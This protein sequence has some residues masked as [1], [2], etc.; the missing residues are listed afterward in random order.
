[1]KYV[2]LLILLFL[3]LVFDMRSYKVPN[4]LVLIGY[5]TGTIS[6]CMQHGAAGILISLISIAI[7]WL[8]FSPFFIIRGLGGGDCKLLA[9][10]PLFLRYE[11][12]LECYFLIFA[13]A[14][15]V[16]ILNYFISRKRR[17]RFSIAAF[18]GVVIL[19]IKELV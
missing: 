5:M 10:V 17:F 7:V 19:Y 18:L 13:C 2:I 9:W 11:L 1:M 14:G 4:V 3:A 8:I 15:M 6:L 12:I 16:G